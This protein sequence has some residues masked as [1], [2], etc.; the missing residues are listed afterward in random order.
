MRRDRLWFFRLPRLH[1]KILAPH[2]FSFFSPERICD[3]ANHYLVLMPL[4]KITLGV[5]ECL[6]EFSPLITTMNLSF[7]N[8]IKIQGKNGEAFGGVTELCQ[9]LNAAD[10]GKGLKIPA[11]CI[12]WRYLYHSRLRKSGK[13]GI[14]NLFQNKTTVLC[15][16]R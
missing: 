8:G 6:D 4:R 15:V 10:V 7:Q 3:S 5:S 13:D 9:L 14:K 2:P 1:R 16:G 12:H 11:F